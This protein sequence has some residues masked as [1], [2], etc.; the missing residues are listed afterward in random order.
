MGAEG[1]THNLDNDG[2]ND[3]P[4]LNRAAAKVIFSLYSD[5]IKLSLDTGAAM[6]RWLLTALVAI[7]G[8][9]AVAVGSLM[10]PPS[11]KVIS[12]VAFGLGILFALGASLAALATMPAML[13]PIGEATG[14]WLTVQLDGERIENDI[15]DQDTKL[16]AAVKKAGRWPLVLAVGSV[17]LFV[18]GILSAGAGIL[19]S[20]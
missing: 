11:L 9:A 6:A 12:C 1:Q 19:W 10:M 2:L 16:T 17:V 4:D 20:N 18:V 8:G 14:Y 13:K 3:D 15:K 5:M 7:N